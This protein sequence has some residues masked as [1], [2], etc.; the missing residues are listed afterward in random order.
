VAQLSTHDPDRDFRTWQARCTTILARKFPPDSSDFDAETLARDARRD[1]S[2]L[3]SWELICQEVQDTEYSHV[4]LGRCYEELVRR[5]K[6]DA[7]I[8]E[9]RALAWHTAGWLNFAM[10]LWDWTSLDE[11]DIER[12]IDALRKEKQISK[13]ERAKMLAVL[14]QHS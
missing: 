4:Y 7:Q 10:M 2:G 3:G 5:G 8:Q 1:F 6:T 12:A 11:S 9:M 13:E 14:R